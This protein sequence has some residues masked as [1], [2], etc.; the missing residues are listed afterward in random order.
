MKRVT[1]I[2]ILTISGITFAGGSSYRIDYDFAGHG[3]DW[4]GH[5]REPTPHLDYSI[6]TDIKTQQGDDFCN[7]YQANLVNYS[8]GPELIRTQESHSSYEFLYTGGTRCLS[9]APP[10]PKPDAIFANGFE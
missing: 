9:F 6:L 3:D 1:L 2:V 5:S 7:G 10:A 8:Q 4:Y